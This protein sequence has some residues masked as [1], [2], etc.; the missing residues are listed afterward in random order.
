AFVRLIRVVRVPILA[1]KLSFISRLAALAY[2]PS[3]FLS[4]TKRVRC[5]MISQ[6]INI[7]AKA[8]FNF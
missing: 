4:I 2:V 8:E 1:A 6:K 3:Y 7:K 5:R